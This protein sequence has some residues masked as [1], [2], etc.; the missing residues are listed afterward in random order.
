M[1]LTPVSGCVTT[2]TNQI[3]PDGAIRLSPNPTQHTITVTYGSQLTDKQPTL[4]I[5]GA[6]G[7]QLADYPHVQSGRSLDLTGLPA[8]LLL[9]Q[10]RAEGEMRTLR[11]VKEG[12]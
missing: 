11:V 5:F 1:L 2:S 6:D 4:R 8:G 3:I 10:F 7:R 9:F 12:R